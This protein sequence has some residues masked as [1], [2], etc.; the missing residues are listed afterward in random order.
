MELGTFGAILRFAIE[1]E[2]RAAAFYEQSAQA[3]GGALFEEMAQ[4][5]RKRVG[6]LEQARREGVAEMILESISGLDGDRYTISLDP[7]ADEAGRLAQARALEE[8]ATRFYQ[9]AA[10]KLPIREVS[11]LFQ[12]LAQDHD[13]HRAHLPP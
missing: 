13:Q 8:A 12:R 9:D 7:G 1:L 2:Q 6:R 10:V 11:R 4:G 5:A 3:G